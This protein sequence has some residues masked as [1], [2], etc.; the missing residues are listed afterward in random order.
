MRAKAE[1]FI[2]II[3]L[4]FLIGTVGA[5]GIPDTVL[6]TTEKPWI[7]ANNVDQSTITV[8][9]MNTTP[10]L[11]Y[12]VVSGVTVNL[13]VN[14]TLY[15][16]LSPTTVTTNVSG[17]ASS[18]FKAKTKSGAAQITVS[19]L[20][21]SGIQNIDHDSPYYPY[22][23]YPLTGEVNS[24][25][26]FNIFVTDRW[27]NPI[28]NRK[29][30]NLSLP[31]HT[32]SLHVH[33]PAPDDCY[34]V[35][36]GHDISPALESNGNF[37]VVVNLTSKIG[38]NYIL[39]DQFGSISEKVEWIVVE[40]TG[41]PYSMTG[42]ISDG[43][44]LPVDTTPFIIDYF[45]YDVFGNPVRNQSIWVNTTLNEHKTYTTNSLGQ[46]RLYYGPMFTAGDITINATPLRN[47][48]I[49][50]TTVAHFINSGPSDMLLA[51]TPQT[52]ASLDTLATQKQAF[53]RATVIDYFGN[54]VPNE[55]V[56]F[57]L[58]TVSAVGF[59]QNISPTLSATTAVTSNDGNAI[60]I[61]Y[62]GSFAKRGEPGYNGTATGTVVVTATW[63]GTSKSVKT[64]WKNYAY[65]NIMASAEPKNVKLNETVDITIDVVGDGYNMQGGPVTAILDQDTSAN[66]F[67]GGGWKFHDSIT[68]AK[69]FVGTCTEGQDYIGVTAYSDTSDII[70]LA[71][72]PS[73]S[74]VNLALDNLKKGNKADFYASI[75]HAIHN[76][77]ETQPFRPPDRVR[78]V[79]ILE[80]PGGTSLKEWEMDA[81]K[82]E[83]GS[84]TPFTYLFVAFYD[85][86]GGGT[87]CLGAAARTAANLT[88][89]P[90]QYECLGNVNDL[91]TAYQN[92]SRELHTRA[93]VNTS[94]ALDF[95][96]IEQDGSQ[97]D[98][99]EAFSY[100]P[101]NDTDS[102]P[103]YDL[104]TTPKSRDS[105]VGRTRIMWPNSS[106]SVKNQFDEWNTSQK[107][108]FDIGT[109]NI[110]ERWNATYRL[111]AVNETGLM[112]LFN[113]TMSES[114]LLYNDNEE[115]PVCLPEL[116][117]MVT[118][119]T[120]PANQTGLD[121][122][123]L[124]VT[125]SGNI[126]DY[127]PLEWNLEYAGF[128]IAT[129]TINYQYYDGYNFGPLIQFTS[130][131][132]IA[133][134]NYIQVAQLDVKKFPPGRYKI[135]VNASAK[136][137]ERERGD[138]IEV[139]IGDTGVFI[140][141]T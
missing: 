129:E 34:F 7:I 83:A 1:I 31:N 37:S 51:V 2:I 119:A 36:S 135:Y 80:D 134:G 103:F 47:S 122:W 26:L 64:T 102:R 21:G 25:I 137:V 92:F 106:H 35:G 44:I 140:L 97:I 49:M 61:F 58:G 24:E 139:N 20:S 38:N 115:P 6:V 19:G 85:T 28:D 16:T 117:I 27:A 56:S 125:K 15:G 13:V 67:G 72:T 109:V 5:V 3:S 124:H 33:G 54:P 98:G 141:L 91:I 45:L 23:S 42:T 87:E 75:S 138:S 11:D 100:V 55:T 29:E 99:F 123:N 90:N 63:N 69:A 77:T 53:V 52:M 59:T 88:N 127:I 108:H 32:V 110:S 73:L 68:A 114:R 60:V 62:P 76:M 136:D 84:T 105:I 50:N 78:A 74:L 131:S 71:P 41:K 39:M 95:G 133:P 128:D 118:N 22:F 9:V 94:L 14:N 4:L 12:G 65:L 79:I 57:S 101:V 116:P 81:L 107:L 132:D 121:V 113:C 48:S 96:K 126:T 10:G 46:V 93:G 120:P 111:R 130:R 40:A 8:T 82:T 70:N 112:N 18:T 43:G 17:K 89:G 104:D 66:I 30:I 86:A